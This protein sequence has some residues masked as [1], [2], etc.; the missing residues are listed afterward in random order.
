[1]P[2]IGTTEARKPGSNGYTS[3]PM[4]AY[5]KEFLNV[6]NSILENGRVDIFTE[7]S[8]MLRTDINNSTMKEFFIENSCDPKGMT[9]EELEDHYVMMEQLYKN[10][11]AAVLEHVGMSNYNPVIGMTFP[12]HKNIMLN[13]IFDKGA[14]P[15]LVATSPKFTVSM[16]TRWL[17]DPVTGQKIDMWREQYKMTDAIEKA[18]PMKSMYMALPEAENTN[19]LTT[20]FGLA[21]DGINNLSLESYLSGVVVTNAALGRA[22]FPGQKLQLAASYTDAAG[23]TVTEIVT[24]TNDTQ[25][26]ELIYAGCTPTG[27]AWTAWATGKTAAT[28]VGPIFAWKGNF[29]PAYGGYDRQIVEQF[30]VPVV[31]VAGGI[32]A[33]T[34][35][36]T[37]KVE[38][39]DWSDPTMATTVTID[40]ITSEEAIPGPNRMR[41]FVSGFSK[42]NRFGITSSQT[43]VGGVIFTSRIDTSSAQLKTPSVSWD[44]RTD[45]IE[46][47]NR[48][49]INV[50]ISPE[51]VK[52]IAA[53]YQINQLTKVMSLMKISLGNYKDDLIRRGL[54]E[55]Y[56]TM[57]ADCKIGRSFDFAPTTNYALDPVEWRH[58]TFMDALDTHAT[59]LLH[60]LND[61]NVTFNI[62]GR[63]DL[64]RKITPTDYTYQSP[65]SIGP[66]E[67]DFVKT[68][69]TSD[70]RTYQFISSDKLRDSNNLMIILCP[71]NSE[72]FIY[73]IYDY[74]MYLSNEIRNAQNPSLPAVH[75]FERWIMKSYQPVQGR[76]RILN[77]TGL[78]NYGTDYSYNTD[79]IG[80]GDGQASMG[81][82]F[83]D[84]DKV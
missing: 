11:K 39:V 35:A 50:T 60:V 28:V 13:N 73:R 81:K 47:P 27:T 5:A 42:N 80:R 21:E 52:D 69:V 36:D 23:A 70:K 71:R 16:E 68:V 84:I 41:G 56:V 64:I 76:I 18:A 32:T 72:R 55:S 29:A 26:A 65:S 25:A 19:V 82:N 20:L 15:K 10:D 17:I 67:L 30:A 24:Y 6:A 7:A 33:G 54:D 78:R 46:I 66:V 4:L 45:I 38:A 75:A 1:M 22:C 43:A 8:K 40:N 51:E 14:I 49:P 53:L 57:P 3:D 31:A 59:Q 61:P 79:P 48:I 2:V 44:I 34:L 58:K 37:W 77:P 63:D 9:P 62:I 12:I 74:Q 83:F